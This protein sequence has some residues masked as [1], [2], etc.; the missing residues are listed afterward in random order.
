VSHLFTYL[1]RMKFI[2]RWGLTHTTYA[3]A[4]RTAAAPRRRGQQE[5]AAVQVG[6]VGPMVAQVN[7][8]SERSGWLQ[9][10]KPTE[11]DRSRSPAP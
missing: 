6:M 5:A 4:A 8:R 7:L 1:A 2:K 3:R 10:S 11:S 9:R